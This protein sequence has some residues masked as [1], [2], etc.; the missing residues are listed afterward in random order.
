MWQEISH[1]L[2]ENVLFFKYAT[3]IC[4]GI[5]PILSKHFFFQA[6]DAPEW[7]TIIFPL[8]NVTW[9]P[10]HFLGLFKWY[11]LLR[12]LFSQFSCSQLTSNMNF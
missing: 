9:S 3:I 10:L 7:F 4:V 6:I 11:D 5:K 8:A 12:P 2:I 1:F